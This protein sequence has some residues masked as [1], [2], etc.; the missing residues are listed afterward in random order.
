MTVCAASFA[1][2]LFGFGFYFDRK[3][4]HHNQKRMCIVHDTNE[5][6]STPVPWPIR[7]S[8]QKL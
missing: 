2:L 7:W 1:S 4:P 3:T 5:E 6:W 8:E